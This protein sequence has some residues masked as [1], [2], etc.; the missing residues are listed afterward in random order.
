MSVRSN[1]SRRQAERKNR[2]AQPT[3]IQSLEPRTLLSASF[4]VSQI[5]AG[6]HTNNAVLADVN[7]DGIPDLV[8]THDVYNGQVRVRL[9][10]GNGTFGPADRI[11]VG[12]DP[13]DVIVADLTRNGRNDIVVTNTLTGTVSVIL[14][15]PQGG[16]ESP[17]SFA[18]GG[19]EPTLVAAG[20]INGDTIPDLIVVNS[21]YGGGVDYLLGNGD[22]TFQTALP[23]T[24][25]NS[26][27]YAA[28]QP[29]IL[30]DVVAVGDLTGDG[31]PDLL[32]KYRIGYT[33]TYQLTV[34]EG[35]GNS[36]F[37]R[38][39]NVNAGVATQVFEPL[40]TDPSAYAIGDLNGDGLPDLV[41]AN[42]GTYSDVRVFLNQGAGV[43]A[44]PLTF[45]TGFDPDSIA[46]A[47]VNG[48]GQMDIITADKNEQ[49]VSV[50]AGYGNGVFFP[51]QDVSLGSTDFPVFV[52]AGDVNGDG[53]PD[54]VTLNSEAPNYSISILQNTTF[55]A[56]FTNVTGHTLTVTGTPGNDTIFANSGNPL[57]TVTENGVTSQSFPL[58]GITT[59]NI[60]GDDGN[61]SIYVG[62][63]LRPGTVTGGMSTLDAGTGS[64]TIVAGDF[65]TVYGGAG[66]DYLSSGESQGCLLTG[67]V[68]GDTLQAGEFSTTLIGGAGADV[69]LGG[70]GNDS[71]SG[72]GGPDTLIAG[73]G[74]STLVGGA[75]FD[76]IVG[77][78]GSDL[79]DGAAG[80]DTIVAVPANTTTQNT[81]TLMGGLGNDSMIFVGIDWVVGGGGSD[82]LSEQLDPY[83]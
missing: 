54:L 73:P 51:A 70:S 26:T 78:I 17:L 81:S 35:A 74:N 29:L 61:D 77:G 19:T 16:F 67:N 22:G 48:D 2:P 3:E 18:T 27:T 6:A 10:N 36:T 79:L 39:F 69:L 46:L 55:E 37:T 1:K 9:G 49:A 4:N 75:G 11:P 71:M 60:V 32:V 42:Y 63:G 56:S 31:I 24:V 7:G 44:A 5:G 80:G 66:P 72:G 47:D 52:G 12:A 21:G 23:V 13:S 62:Q 40:G 8:L 14:Q 45:A 59:M 68:S 33:N 20:D 76:S 58:V 41:V 30:G 43:L 50:L 57:F 53:K 64:D 82:T 34:L 28:V 15:N 38:E 83:T 25:V 65:E